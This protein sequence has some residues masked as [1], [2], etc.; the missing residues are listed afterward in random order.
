MAEENLSACLI[1]LERR[2]RNLGDEPSL[3]AY[4]LIRRELRRIKLKIA[5]A[6][7]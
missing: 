6:S 1:G 7:I 4:S 2:A 3:A 5:P